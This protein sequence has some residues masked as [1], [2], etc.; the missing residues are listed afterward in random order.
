MSTRAKLTSR[1]P[2]TCGGKMIF[3]LPRKKFKQEIKERV[4]IACIGKAG[5]NK[6][7]FSNIMNDEGRAA[8]RCGMGALMGSK[9]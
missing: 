9:T 3:T 5:E 1:M 4:S 8:G 2:R 7:H 6:I